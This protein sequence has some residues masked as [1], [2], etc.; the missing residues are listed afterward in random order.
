MILII[1]TL[2]FTIGMV[3]IKFVQSSYLEHTGDRMHHGFLPFFKLYF[4]IEFF[5]FVQSV[6]RSVFRNTCMRICMRICYTSHPR[7]CWSNKEV[8]CVYFLD[9]IWIYFHFINKII[10]SF[11]KTLIIEHVTTVS[12]GMLDTCWM[13]A[14]SPAYPVKLCL[15]MTLFCWL[16]HWLFVSHTELLCKHHIKFQN[17][18][19]KTC[20]SYRNR[21]SHP[22]KGG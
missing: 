1:Y 7:W 9:I 18:E 12:F 4:L 16:F 11:E 17:I 22:W 21:D 3:L 10:P 14:F 13:D 15:S 20:N 5:F 8:K 6:S 2:D 19:N